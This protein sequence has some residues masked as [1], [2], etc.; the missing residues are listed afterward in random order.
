MA[1]H[2]NWW[3]KPLRPSRS[4]WRSNKEKGPIQFLRRWSLE[5]IKNGSL[6][7][8]RRENQSRRKRTTTR[9]WILHLRL[10]KQSSMSTILNNFCST[11][12]WLG[13]TTNVQSLQVSGIECC[14]YFPQMV[15]WE[16]NQFFL[17]NFPTCFMSPWNA[18][19]IR[20]HWWFSSCNLPQ[21]RQMMAALFMVALQGML[22]WKNVRLE[23][24]H[25]I[26]FIGLKWLGSSTLMAM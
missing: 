25:F 23:Q 26:F 14:F 19:E 6:L 9:N 20:I 4:C 16:G 15:F 12:V 18:S 3:T 5:T 21:V 13:K 2:I 11:K 24:L 22:R 10:W 7:D 17:P 8:A 1:S